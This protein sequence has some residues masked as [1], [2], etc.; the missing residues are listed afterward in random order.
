MRAI[1]WGVWVAAAVALTFPAFL[2]HITQFTKP[3]PAFLALILGSL[4]ALI[5]GAGLHYVLRAAAVHRYSLWMVPLVPALISAVYE[6]IGTLVIV[7]IAVAA[8]VLGRTALV[9]AGIEDAEAGAALALPALT[10]LGLLTY[11]LFALGMLGFFWR[12]T[13]AVVLFAALAIG[14]R[15][16]PALAETCR[17]LHGRWAGD[18]SARSPVV[19]LCVVV[20]AALAALT[21]VIA[22]TP[23]IAA[24]ALTFHLNLTR[25]YAASG[26]MQPPETLAYGW[27]PQAFEAMMTAAWVFGEQPAAQFVGVQFFALAALLVAAIVRACGYSRAS[28][29]AAAAIAAPVPFIHWSGSVVK[30]DLM[31]AA[32]LL[33]ALYSVLRWRAAGDFRWILLSAFFFGLCL[34]VKHIAVFGLPPLLVL[35]A[36]AIWRQPMRRVAA[37]DLA[38]V[39]L[40][41]GSFSMARTYLVMG[42]PV[43]PASPSS[44]VEW[45]HSVT[46]LDRL[47]RF[48]RIPWALHFDGQRH[49]ETSSNNPM[50]VAAIV[51]LPALLPLT[52][53]RS[54]WAERACVWFLAGYLLYWLSVVSV[55]RYAIAAF[56]L[57]FGLLAAR[58]AAAWDVG[59]WPVRVA[60]GGGFAYVLAFAWVTTVMIESYPAEL[61]YLAR[62]IDAN[63]FLRASLP[64][65]GA[66]EFLRRHAAHEDWVL[67]LGAYAPVYGHNPD[68]SVLINRPV[69]E[70]T[71]GDI[72]NALRDRFEYRWVVL[73][74]SGKGPELARLLSKTRKVRHMY[75]DA[76]F[77]VYRLEGS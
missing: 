57:L 67:N 30:N 56:A 74:N 26:F 27:F 66:M 43:Y 47:G 28:A 37:A 39:C 49:F 25:S 7:A 75:G 42:N 20:S 71:A 13:V 50:G 70:F 53:R 61:P 14:R 44:S 11:T 31:L 40:L 2:W 52:G 48:A 72:L 10:G 69:T 34:Q 73:P 15:H 64:P 63:E 36:V 51:L 1:I 35:W 38:A 65:F 5:A 62:R 68:R 29:V 8:W 18:E 4:A 77:S 17:G 16:L 41:F 19:S 32:W 6:P 9:W 3:G 59:R 54:A 60:I 55:L 12:S 58:A 21:A 45:L 46:G 23:S 22:V 24:D 76:W 33:A